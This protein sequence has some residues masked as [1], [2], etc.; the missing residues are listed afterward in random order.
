MH[1]KLK[2]KLEKEDPHHAEATLDSFKFKRL[3]KIK[4]EEPFIP[5]Q[6]TIA[7]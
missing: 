3:K 4:I 2:M 1:D 6:E 7:G 5:P